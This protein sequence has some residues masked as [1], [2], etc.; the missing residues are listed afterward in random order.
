MEQLS[1][2]RALCPDPV[3]IVRGCDPDCPLTPN[4][5]VMER[6]VLN[7][8]KMA[9]DRAEIQL[10]QHTDGLWMWATAAHGTNGGYGYNV[11]PKW[12]RFAK[13]RDEAL[14]LAADEIEKR[15]REKREQGEAER[16]IFAWCSQKKQEA[17]F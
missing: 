7:H 2:F 4:D 1:M 16:L 5:E 12:G 13:T 11:G 8:P 14:W 9:F 17:G 15:I 3:A 6:L 10:H